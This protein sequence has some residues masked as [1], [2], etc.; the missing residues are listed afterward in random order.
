[1]YVLK[2]RVIDVR[3]ASTDYVTNRRAENQSRSR[4]DYEVK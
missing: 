1:M 3:M 2:A 4:Y